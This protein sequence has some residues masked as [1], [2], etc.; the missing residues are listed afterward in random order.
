MDP[1]RLL[2]SWFHFGGLAES[3][4]SSISFRFSMLREYKVLKYYKNLNFF[5]FS[6]NI[7]LFISDYVGFYLSF[8]Y[9][10]QRSANLIFSKKQLL[11]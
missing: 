9:S 7:S 3:R 6:C 11:D 4:N 2:A 10:G 8:N 1:I 5:G